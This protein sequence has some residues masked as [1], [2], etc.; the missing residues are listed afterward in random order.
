MHSSRIIMD[1]VLSGA[2]HCMFCGNQVKDMGEGYYDHLRLSKG[3]ESAWRTWREN[4]IL[5]H[6]GGD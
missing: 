1:N 6:P 2:A 3:C 4:L 5:D